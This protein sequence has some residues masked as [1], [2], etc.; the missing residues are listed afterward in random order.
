MNKYLNI[1]YNPYW[2]THNYI[3]WLY[4]VYVNDKLSEYDF[5]FDKF[6]LDERDYSR[7]HYS[8][9]QKIIYKRLKSTFKLTNK[10][11]NAIINTTGIKKL[12]L[13]DK[14]KFSIETTNLFDEN[15]FNEIINFYGYKKLNNKIH[16]IKLNQQ[17]N[18]II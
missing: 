10:N 11:I 8:I 7:P 3:S 15:L 6:S 17:I 2:K 14:Y 5:Y 12:N 1:F 18:F 16:I 4:G 9:W 13:L